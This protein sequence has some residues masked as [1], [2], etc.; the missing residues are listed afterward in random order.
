MKKN[1]IIIFLT[2]IGI[3][4]AG[5]TFYY[6]AIYTPKTILNIEKT[7][8]I[9]LTKPLDVEG[10]TSNYTYHDSIEVKNLWQTTFLIRNIGSRTI[11]GK[12]FPE[13][14][15]RYSYMP[16]SVEGCDNVLS[17]SITNENNGSQ[18]LSP[19]KLM[20]I[21]WKPKEYVEI[22]T[23]TDGENSPRLTINDREIKDSEIIYSVYSPDETKGNKKIIEYLPYNI[24]N[25][26]KWTVTIVI[27]FLLLI[28]IPQMRKQY[29][30]LEGKAMKV[31]FITF[32]ILFLIIMLMPFLWMF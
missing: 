15:I 22:T 7:S 32:F 14:S 6:Q 3:V 23:L 18:I 29:I 21:Q 25:S 12:G 20:I 28:A 17:A 26:L 27:G 30:C 13:Q 1:N 16:F 2:I 5:F 10:L 11:Y 8:E 24:V 31:F 19:C 9:L 4:I